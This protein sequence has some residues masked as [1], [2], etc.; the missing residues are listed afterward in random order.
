LTNA[1]ELTH[2]SRDRILHAMGEIEAMLRDQPEFVG[3]SREANKRMLIVS[4]LSVTYR[5]DYR[6]RIV[7]IL[8]ARVHRTKP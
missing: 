2:P 8:T 3:E 7:H 1:H 6:K 4:P 5:I